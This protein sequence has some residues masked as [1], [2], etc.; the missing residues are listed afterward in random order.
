MAISLNAGAALTYMAG[1]FDAIKSLPG[2]G[3]K[4]DQRGINPRANRTSSWIVYRILYFS[5]SDEAVFICG[6]LEPTLGIRPFRQPDP[7]EF[8]CRQL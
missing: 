4:S 6:S 2:K 1:V 8:I 3:C 7:L 5:I